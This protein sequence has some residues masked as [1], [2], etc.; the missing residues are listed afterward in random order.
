MSIR[1]KK[2]WR[3]KVQDAKGLPK[4]VPLMGKLREKLGRGTM[5][6]PAPAEVEALMKRVRQGNL[7]TINELRAKL[8]KKHRATTAC[9]IT[10]GI[11]A[12]LAAHAADEAAEAGAKSFTPYWRTLKSDGELNTKYPGGLDRVRALLEAE[13]HV[14]VVKGKKSFVFGFESSLMGSRQRKAKS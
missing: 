8:A 13:G 4:V 2:S 9:P 6:I 3:E 10:T 7:I 5:V 12:W 14:V 11:F 1:K